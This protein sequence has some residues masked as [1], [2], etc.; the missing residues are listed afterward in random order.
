MIY[1]GRVFDGFELHDN[2]EFGID[3]RLGEIEYIEDIRTSSPR[4]GNDKLKVSDVTFLPG[5]IDTHI[6]FFGTESHS[7]NDWV[8]TSDVLLTVKS[9]Y[10]AQKLLLS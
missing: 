3:Q 1:K 7:L 9:V 8:L 6:H 5:L 10:D 4:S 2:A